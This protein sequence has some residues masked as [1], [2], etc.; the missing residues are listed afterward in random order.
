MSWSESG[1]ATL[2]SSV[3]ILNDQA[4]SW[5]MSGHCNCDVTTLL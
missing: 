5:P 1:V 4:M 3:A 2:I